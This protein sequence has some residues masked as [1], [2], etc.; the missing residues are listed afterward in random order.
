M[1]LLTSSKIRQSAYDLTASQPLSFMGQVADE[2]RQGLI[3][4][5]LEI[6]HG[7]G[8]DTSISGN[9]PRTKLYT[10]GAALRQTKDL[11]QVAMTNPDIPRNIARRAEDIYKNL[12]F[13]GEKELT[14]ATHAIAMQWKSYL[15]NNPDLSLF[16]VTN[17]SFETE[18]L[19]FEDNGV[20]DD[21]IGH[22]SD[23]KSDE[24]I[25][26]SVLSNFSNEELREYKDRLLFSDSELNGRDPHKVKTIILDDWI[27]S[28]QQMRDTLD[29]VFERTTPADLEIN[30][31][32][33]SEDRLANGFKTNQQAD[34]I[35][36]KARFMARSAD[37]PYASEFGGAYLTAAHST[38]DYPFEGSMQDIIE[39]VNKTVSHREQRLYMPPLTNI[40]RP[41]YSPDYY[42]RNIERLNR[43][44][45]IGS[46]ALL[47]S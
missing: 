47:N 27:M 21:D 10:E 28:G 20:H 24:Y 9:V 40:I 45:A 31:V 25:L 38:G 42:P 6:E 5:A 32:V 15:S 33:S 2:T 19:E 46:K 44:R 26:D 11:L 12:T 13:I 4:S 1:E 7:L 34:P 41:Y 17:K 3:K 39:A 23:N 16:I 43:L 18:D 30:L 22:I 36:I 37:H 29:R 35:P 8:S 14:E